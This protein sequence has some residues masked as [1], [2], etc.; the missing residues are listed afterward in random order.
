MK[1]YDITMLIHKGMPV[2]KN[3]PEKRPEL[4]N[5][6]NFETGSHYES[7]I[8]MDIHTGTHFDA[9]LH[10]VK[11]GDTIENFDLT[12]GI[13]RCKVFDVTHLEDRI[14]EEDIKN[15]DIKAGDFVIFKT[16]NSFAEEFDVSFIF[17][18]KSAAAFLS[19]KGIKGV[20]IDALGVER[21]Q[22][23][24]ETHKILFGSNISIIEGLSLK[25]VPQ[26]EYTLI[27]LPLKIKG[28][29]GAPARAVLIEGALF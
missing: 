11:D 14:T 28:A 7:K 12:K 24:H 9:A 18:D 19:A 15:F 10:M 21:S 23:E 3:K 25:D 13:T 27:A 22:P 26:G 8:S 4:I 5:T 2:Y 20:G 1:I 6:A 17:I 29:E 16:K